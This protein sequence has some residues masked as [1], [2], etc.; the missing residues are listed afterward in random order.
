MSE[1]IKKYGSRR[2]RY[3]GVMT[4]RLDFR[5]S[6]ADLKKLRELAG[7]ARLSLPDYFR[8]MIVAELARAERGNKEAASCHNSK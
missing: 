2:M 5:V 6:E 4:A 8:E 3:G 7:E 1:A